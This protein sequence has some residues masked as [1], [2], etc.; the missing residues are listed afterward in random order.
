MPL[1]RKG[2]LMSRKA[3]VSIFVI[4]LSC[5]RSLGAADAPLTPG[6]ATENEKIEFLLKAIAESKLKFVRNDV[7]YDAEQGAAHVRG[8]WEAARDKIASASQFI[9]E[10]GTKSSMSSKAYEVILDDGK[11][12]IPLAAWLKGVLFSAELWEREHQA[13]PVAI[14]TG[15]IK[16]L[17][18]QLGDDSF[19]KRE[20]ATLALIQM[21]PAIVPELTRDENE[22]Q[23]AEVKKRC[24]QI[25][26]ALKDADQTAV[27]VLTYIEKSELTFLREGGKHS[28]FDGP[29]FSKWLQGKAMLQDVSLTS[30]AKDF[31]KRIASKS[32]LHNTPYQV[33]LKS[34]EV[35]DVREWLAK[36]YKLE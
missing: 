20:Q 26:E 6:Q 23:D 16:K 10:C 9:D 17:V 36:K 30:S 32:S 12:T 28:D 2:Y 15:S 34:G 14:D 1:E 5:L 4:A 7:Q 25:R 13:R 18:A 8:K 31:I 24:A 27:G 19:E 29:A 11:T 35:L 33:R 21:G 3:A 22:S